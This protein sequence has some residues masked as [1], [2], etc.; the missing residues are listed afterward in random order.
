MVR[1]ILVALDYSSIG[2]R[3]LDQALEFAKATG[4]SLVL[5]HVF[6]L[7]DGYPTMVNVSPGSGFSTSPNLSEVAIQAAMEDWQQRQQTSLDQLN[8]LVDRAKQAGVQ[9]E[10]HHI[11]GQP[12]RVICDLAK[13]LKV[14][15]ILMGRQGRSGLSEAILGSVSNYV[16]HHAGR[17]VWIVQETTES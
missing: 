13:E 6:S 3:I 5:L 16:V 9:A 17:S 12:G 7:V 14:D 1:K 8:H 15:L 4:A 11:F 2:D 10:G